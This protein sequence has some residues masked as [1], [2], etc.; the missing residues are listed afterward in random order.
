[1]QEILILDPPLQY[2]DT[3]TGVVHTVKVDF[4]FPAMV[5]S[6]KRMK[7]GWHDLQVSSKATESLGASLAATGRALRLAGSLYGVSTRGREKCVIW[8]L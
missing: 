6:I 5:E 2:R 3:T 4:V 1:M 8:E 7:K